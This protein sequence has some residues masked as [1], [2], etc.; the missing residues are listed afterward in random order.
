MALQSPPPLSERMPLWVVLVPGGYWFRQGEITRGWSYL[1]GVGILLGVLTS[2]WGR[3]ALPGLI[4]LGE[5]PQI[6]QGFDMIPGDHSLHFLVDGLL[7]LVMAGWTL[8]LWRS[9]SGPRPFPGLL[10]PAAAVLSLFSLLP[11]ISTLVLGFT[12]YRAPDRLPPLALLNW[13]GAMNFQALF[14]GEL[15]S[16]SFLRILS[17]NTL[18]ALGVT[19][20]SFLGAAALSELMEGRVLPGRRVF[21]FIFFLPYVL[22]SYFTLLVFRS[23][24]GPQGLVNRILEAANLPS[25]AFLS[26]PLA[27]KLTVLGVNIWLTLPF[28][29]LQVTSLRRQLPEEIHQAAKLDGAGFF[30][31]FFQITLP[32]VWYRVRPAVF[33]SFLFQFNNFQGIFVL[34]GGGPITGSLHYAGE[35][36]ILLSWIYRL[37]LN[38]GLF[39]LA[40]VFTLVLF[41]ILGLLA[42]VE[43]KIFREEEL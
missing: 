6:R 20:M 25:A 7:F 23:L 37:T 41:L 9:G 12:D 26:D 34:T 29:F 8:F 16:E 4:S 27:A 3:S 14:Q 38:H 2:P 36:D 22:P 32:L 28:F 35:T 30:T 5:T 18:W 33:F 17:W 11:M 15:W 31:R 1:L 21:E 10:I 19:S 39:N 42:L 40:A 13:V 24:M 43:G